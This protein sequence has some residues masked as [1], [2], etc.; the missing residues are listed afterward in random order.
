M[1]NTH[2]RSCIRFFAPMMTTFAL[3][4]SSA[5]FAQHYQQTDLVANSTSVSSTATIDPNLVNAWDSH[6][7]QVL[8]GGFLTMGRAFQ[9]STTARAR[10]F[11]S[12]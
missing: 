4:F 12:W 10:L 6:A 11:H 5:A 7:R 1:L 2:G 3:L 8:P 9:L